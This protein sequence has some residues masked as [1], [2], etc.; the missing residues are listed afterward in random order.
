[1]AD[2]SSEVLKGKMAGEPKWAIPLYRWLSRWKI[3]QRMWAIS[4]LTLS[5][6]FV[7]AAIGWHG[8]SASRDSLERV[9]S[10]RAVPLQNLSTLQKAVF[11]NINDLQQGWEH[12]PANPNAAMHQDHQVVDHTRPIKKRRALIDK[13]LTSY[14]AMPGKNPEETVLAA[15]FQKAYQAWD[16]IFTEAYQDLSTETFSPDVHRHF[17]KAFDNELDIVNEILD[18][19]IGLQGRIA[20]E[21]FDVAEAAFNRNQIIFTSLIIGGAFVVLLAVFLTVRHMRNLLADTSRAVEAIAAGDLSKEVHQFGQDELGEMTKSIAVMRDKLIDIIRALLSDVET[22]RI[23]AA[24]LS[25]VAADNARDA[26]EQLEQTGEATRSVQNLGRSIEKTE[27]FVALAGDVTRESEGKSRSGGKIITET[28]LEM[29][30]I[31]EVV[32]EISSMVYDLENHSQRISGVTKTIN[33][34]AAQ[35]NLL[36]LNAAIEAARAGESGKG[37]AVVATEVR[38]LSG[39]TANATKDINQLLVKIQDSIAAT[40]KKMDVGVQH[41]VLGTTLTVAAGKAIQEIQM[42]SEQVMD[43]V[44][45][46]DEAFR[47]QAA[48]GKDIVGIIEKVAGTT[49]RNM[50][51]TARLAQSAVKLESLSNDLHG[52]ANR[53]KL[54]I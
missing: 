40:R 38:N 43:A 7:S 53:F 5:L 2:R 49:A 1:M 52:L 8:L 27:S 19:L 13:L 50:D 11:K 45:H 39:K 21:E 37:F 25:N 16:A 6:F 30:S 23:A 32:N 20:K 10:E 18:G 41:V 15:D 48:Y 24:E 3:A 51:S 47:E 14:L 42:G 31:A 46:I 26:G 9:F 17:L 4:I 34:I 12:A 33:G 35:T 36:A 28:S 22:L 44:S 54:G 29:Q